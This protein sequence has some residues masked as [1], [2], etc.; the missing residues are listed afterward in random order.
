MIGQTISHYR[1]IEK[2]GGGGM[3]VVYKAE[4]TRL[5]RFV[6]L[7][8]LP[9]DV[10][11]D[12]HALARFQREAEAASA[13]NHPNIC[14][15][16]DIGQQ[17]G[18]AFIAM[19]F[20]DGL[21]L[22]HRIAGRAMQLDLLLSLATEIAEGLDAAH[23]AGIVHRD[24]KPANIFITK[25]G[26]AKIL[27]FGLAKLLVNPAT[28][29]S[30]AATTIDGQEHLTTPGVAI[31]TIAYMSP[32][33]ARG[34][35]L[36]SRSDVFSF[37][38]VLYE[39]ATGRMAFPGDTPGVI[40]NAILDRD[41]VSPLRL[42][43][44]VP[45]RLE[46]IINKALEKDRKLRYQHASEMSADLRRLQRDSDSGGRSSEAARLQKSRRTGVRQRALLFTTGSLLSLFILS[47]VIFRYDRGAWPI[48]FGPKVPLQKNLVVL[49]F[50][51]VGGGSDE[52]VYCDGFTET[53]T[54]GLARDPSLQVPSSLEIRA[55]N[56]SSIEN[57]R[58]QFGANLVLAATWQRI[59][60][61]ARINLSLVDTKTGQ[62]LRADTITEPADD[63]FTLQDQ[64][65]L[66]TLRMLQLQPPR[67][68]ATQALA[69]G[70]SV[71]T[72]YDFYV[73]GIGYLQRY[74]RLENVE[75]AITLFQ[76]AIKEDP[77]YAQALAALAQ[78]YWYKYSATKEPQWVD[79]AKAAVKAAE[80]LDS[81]LPEVQLAI[82]NVNRRT[83]AYPAALSA[84]QSVLE[85]DPQNLDAYQ[86]LGRTYDALGRTVEAEQAF[87]HTIEIR[88]ACWSCYNVLGVF[89][90]KHAR[91]SEAADA[92]RKVT[93]LTPDNVWGYMNVGA[94]YFNMGQFEMA[95]TYFQRGLQVAP[96][97]ADLLANAGTVSFFLERFDED[98]RY[99]KKAIDLKPRK[100]DYWGNLGDAYR[101][102]PSEAEARVA[103]KQA[104]SL[105]EKEL[106][107][108]PKDS[109][110]LSLLALWYS[111]M[112]EA[113]QARKYLDA[114]LR[115]NPSNVDVLRIACLV[116]LEA[117]EKQEALKWLEKSVHAG[118]SREQLMANPELAELRSQS[119]FARI[120]A[121]AVSFK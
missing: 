100:Y 51:A 54:A 76:R 65:V 85:L 68:S 50:K 97:N 14:T 29:E 116:H 45:P 105:A 64:V 99:T 8:F 90:N 69:H 49:P 22:K 42:C 73:Q 19:E 103:Y 46:E 2:L 38:A 33:Q 21:T 106:T 82:G 24:I 102:I 25:S 5:H 31:G 109:D 91:Y 114:A 74:E 16:Y 75:S 117:G 72:A 63:L 27:D 110:A 6:G 95:E 121:G 84:F 83:G 4:D 81:R 30:A 59:G 40:F 53:V 17:D 79:Q 70:T 104:I 115:A 66:K 20:L 56:V 98:I 87:R 71:L 11:H 107:V 94:V 101:M 34:R 86:G 41:P 10:A 9:D 77:K 35:E 112:G 32:E 36:D 67:G 43:P 44:Q 88:P 7:K 26:H 78:A 120:A 96:S 12:P 118:Y 23:A 13:L 62:Q 92:W 3:G 15:I 108:N 1:V 80:K 60:H 113:A 18:R 111:R 58:M 39:M 57:A 119:E 89:L 37:G 61:N 48:G 28:S 93:E 52:Q 47:V 55:K